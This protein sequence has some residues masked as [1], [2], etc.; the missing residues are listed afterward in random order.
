MSKEETANTLWNN[1]MVR[2][3]MKAMTPEQRQHYKEVGEQMYGNMNFKNSTI[4]I[5][6]AEQMVEAKLYIT[7][8]LKSGLHPSDMDENE[9]MVMENEYGAEWYKKWGYVMEDLERIV[10]LK[11]D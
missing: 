3:A 11:K 7:E 5:E 4:S 8:L 6:P 10:T 1:P 9:K 2:S